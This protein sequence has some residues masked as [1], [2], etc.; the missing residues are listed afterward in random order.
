MATIRRR[1][2]SKTKQPA[3]TLKTAGKVTKGKFIEDAATI[4]SGNAIKPQGVSVQHPEITR[5]TGIVSVDHR[6]SREGSES[7]AYVP[8]PKGNANATRIRRAL[9]RLAGI[10]ATETAVATGAFGEQFGAYAGGVMA[11]MHSAL[12]MERTARWY[13]NRKAIHSATSALA[14]RGIDDIWDVIRAYAYGIKDPAQ[15]L[16]GE[17]DPAALDTVKS[18]AP[19]IRQAV[20]S[21]DINRVIDTAYT[22]SEALGYIQQPED[23]QPEE[24]GEGEQ[25]EDGE[26]NEGDG[27]NDTN[28]NSGPDTDSSDSDTA[29]SD[30][31]DESSDEKEQD[32]QDGR[33]GERDGNSSAQSGSEAAASNG[34]EQGEANNSTGGE[35]RQGQRDSDPSNGDGNT[36]PNDRRPG[37]TGPHSKADGTRPSDRRLDAVH[38]AQDKATERQDLAAKARQDEARA[39]IAQAPVPASRGAGMTDGHDYTI[40]PD[41]ACIEAPIHRSLKGI[42]ETF[43]TATERMSDDT[44]GRASDYIGEMN[45]GNL[46]VF[47]EERREAGRI[48]IGVDCSGSM[49]SMPAL[50]DEERWL[51]N[52]PLG[53]SNSY[54]AWQCAMALSK[55]YPEALVFGYHGSDDMTQIGHVIPGMRPAADQYEARLS[56]SG[57][58]FTVAGGG[59]PECTAMLYMQELLQGKLEGSSGVIITDGGPNDYDHTHD[60]AH[61]MVNSG[62]AFGIVSVGD[63]T[64]RNPKGEMFQEAYRS[65]LR[66]ARRS[67]ERAT[68][69]KAA[70]HEQWAKKAEDILA[71]YEKIVRSGGIYPPTAEV[72][73]ETINDLPKLTRIMEFLQERSTQGT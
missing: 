30:G 6:K 71:G 31:A 17:L 45:I 33:N 3:P 10:K 52:F 18:L 2:R 51:N 13:H 5:N 21:L 39:A 42:L 8:L 59:T 65:A 40:I 16:T 72:S 58:R 61:K 34:S 15:S 9:N 24:Q 32:Q 22:V 57:N 48:I 20:E 36:K 23:E 49:G 43:N 46:D 27:E 69:S 60:L 4:A 64:W 50:G 68:L 25:C 11:S 19:K 55:A 37:N 29:G 1:T 67:R 62:M 66:E 63:D 41:I 73:I 26:P 44:G 14:S 53:K 47:Y 56:G 38:E 35:Q 70:F 7:T 54:L 12:V 28:G